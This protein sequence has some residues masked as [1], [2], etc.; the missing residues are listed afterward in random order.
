MPVYELRNDKEQVRFI[1]G[2][3]ETVTVFTYN[4]KDD[5]RQVRKGTNK[6]MPLKVARSYWGGLLSLGYREPK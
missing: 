1:P 2:H 5:P 3:D 4:L 6:T